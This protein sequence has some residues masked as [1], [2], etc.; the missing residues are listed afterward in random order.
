MEIM[1][2]NSILCFH[3][4]Y[5]LSI[6]IVLIISTRVESFVSLSP[7]STITRLNTKSPIP[8][9]SLQTRTDTSRPHNVRQQSKLYNQ[10]SEASSGSFKTYYKEIQVP[11]L[12]GIS[13]HDISPALRQAV[14]ESGVRNG[15]VYVLTKHTTTAITINEMEG[16]LVDDA[17]QF[18]LKLAPPLYPYLHNDIHL[19]SGIRI[20]I[21]GITEGGNVKS[22]L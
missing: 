20:H 19:R 13:F 17:R 1:S 7:I 3:R 9:R 11:T 8:I 21:S 18:L 6:I 4:Y 22:M 16:R 10:Q 14:E 15:V 12:K 5:I 2:S